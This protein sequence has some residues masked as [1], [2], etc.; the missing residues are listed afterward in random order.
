MIVPGDRPEYLLGERPAANVVAAPSGARSSG[1]GARL[2]I[3]DDDAMNRELLQE[4]VSRLG[5]ESELA[6]DGW[7]ALAGLHARIDLV[8][9]DAMMPGMDGFEVARRI[10]MDPEHGDLP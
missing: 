2:L 4:M 3:V 7:E 5:H 6:Q 1:S 10:R 8:L 9:L